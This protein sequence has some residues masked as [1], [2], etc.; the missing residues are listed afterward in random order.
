MMRLLLAPLLLAAAPQSTPLPPSI[1]GLPIGAIPKQQLP[2]R[3]CAAYL[4]TVTAG[5]TRALVAMAQADPASLRLSVGGT[6]VDLERTAQS[7]TA[8]FGF[9]QTNDYGGGSISA[10]LTLRTE[11]QEA[12]T[13]GAVVPEATL[14]LDRAGQDSV[15]MPVSGLIGCA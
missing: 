9:A 13:Q 10:V 5:G 4:W 7:G 12:L 15:V 14:R 6:I 3:G 11:T 1:D 8:G 2:R